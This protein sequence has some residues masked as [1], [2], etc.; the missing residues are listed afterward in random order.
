LKKRFRKNDF[1]ILG[2]ILACGSQSFGFCVSQAAG[3]IITDIILK[4]DKN[5]DIVKEI[6]SLSK[7]DKCNERRITWMVWTDS[8]GRSF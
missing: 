2:F 5:K 1:V 8:Q 3:E 6:I 7:G 4:K